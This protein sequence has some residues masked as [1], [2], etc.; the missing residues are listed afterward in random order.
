M[1]QTFRS[2]HIFNS[3][4]LKANLL[5]LVYHRLERCSIMESNDGIVS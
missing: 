4:E 1:A 5:D 3:V 2:L